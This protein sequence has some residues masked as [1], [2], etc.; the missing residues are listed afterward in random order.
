MTTRTK[1]SLF[2]RIRI[3]AKAHIST[4]MSVRLYACIS[5]ATPGAISMKFGM[6]NFYE[7]LSKYPNLFKV[8]QK[9]RTLYMETRVR[10][11]ILIYLSTATGLTPGGSS[12][13][14]TNNTQ[15]N[16]NNSTTQ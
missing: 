2:R 9:H 4:V 15:N 1:A 5:A 10:L 16:T 6:G 11:I 12:T 14:H 8:G 7:N 3:V 13:V